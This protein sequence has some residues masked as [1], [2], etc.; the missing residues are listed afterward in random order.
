MSISFRNALAAAAAIALAAC[1]DSDKT[2]APQVISAAVETVRT[3][4]LPEIRFAAGTVRAATV[5]PLAARVMGNVTRV[6]VA[7]GDRVQAGQIL[8]EID[9]RDA[10]AQTVRARAGVA[11]VEQA[12]G[13]AGS[14]IAAAEA[15]A[16]VAESTFQRYSRLRERGSVSAQE[17]EEAQARHRAAQ[18]ELERAR[19]GRD[20]L[21][22]RRDEVR[23]TNTLAETGLDYTRLRAPISGIVSARLVDPGAQAVP[24]M[25]LFSIE[26][27]DR[28]RV[29]AMVDEQDPIRSG[30]P[31][32]IEI[33]R[34]QIDARV[35][36]V[37]ESVDPATRS[38]LVKIDLARRDGLR[39]GAFARVAFT[40]GTRRG[41]SVPESAVARNGQLET[42][43][44]VDPAGVAR[45]RL[46]T[47][48]DRSGK[49]IEVLSGLS[50][51]ENVVVSH[52]QSL[53]DGVKIERSRI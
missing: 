21:L 6:F 22:A 15:Q 32:V 26:S 16:R 14:A 46:V 10:R 25:P 27:G 34:E 23:A 13:G 45:L 43:F 50:D 1:G 37:V 29:E 12:I 5:A 49:R 8:A 11:E 38:S 41:I 3:A 2:A 4:D 51:G 18:A 20:Q 48:G 52:T 31:V 36:Q 53:R 19:R 35:T 44:V 39:S 33:G 9:D 17:F 24:G 28:Y 30:D 47:L 7:A 40:T 42:L